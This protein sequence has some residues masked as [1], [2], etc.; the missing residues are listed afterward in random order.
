MKRSIILA[1]FCIMLLI[2]AS[3]FAQSAKFAAVYDTDP[4]VAM[5][6]ASACDDS[7]FESDRDDGVLLASMHVPQGKEILAGISAESL[8]LLATAVKGQ[9]GGSGIAAG[10]G[11]VKA[12]V[13]AKNLDTGEIVYPVPSKWITFNARLQALSAKLGGVLLT[14]DIPDEGGEVDMQDACVYEDEFIALLTSNESANHFNVVFKDLL[15]G[16]YKIKAKFYVVSDSF[17]AAT[18]DAC[19]YAGSYVVLKDRIVTLQ[20]VRAV[21]GSLDGPVD[22]D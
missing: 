16:T 20:E 17:A 5:T 4:I 11:K 9:K 8:I 3:A 6:S 21:N 7:D 10:Y 1:G 22:F 19:S 14:C 2:S 15:Q 18:E 12:K 13:Y